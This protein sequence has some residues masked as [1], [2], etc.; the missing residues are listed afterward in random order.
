MTMN[1][2]YQPVDTR[3]HIAAV[4]V[5]QGR[6]FDGCEASFGETE[7]VRHDGCDHDDNDRACRCVDGAETTRRGRSGVTDADVALDGEQN[8]QP[9]GRRVENGRQVVDEALV[10]VTP[11]GRHP[12]GV[13]AKHVEIDIA[14]QGPDSS[15]RGGDGQRDEDDIGWTGAH[16][17]FQQHDTDD[18]V[19]DNCE[20][21]HGRRHVTADDVHPRTGHQLRQRQQVL[22]GC[23]IA[24][25]RYRR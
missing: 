8:R 14:R 5:Q 9:D 12:V 22:L 10:D 4:A 11:A 24:I 16:V 6:K 7:H 18:V 1:E 25:K 23:V 15:Q 19:R 2:R 17:R 13:A 21:D 3:R 20:Q